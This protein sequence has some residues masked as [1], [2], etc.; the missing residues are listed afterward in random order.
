MHLALGSVA[1]GLWAYISG[2]S[3]MHMLQVL[4][5]TSTAI[6]TALSRLNATSNCHT[7]LW[8][9]KNKLLMYYRQGGEL[10]D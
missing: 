2:K 4:C 7:Y 10:E 1:L 6:V 5:N 8:G 3:Q 9:Y